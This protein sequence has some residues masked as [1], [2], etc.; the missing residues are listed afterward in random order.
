MK[1]ENQSVYYGI[2]FMFLYLKTYSILSNVFTCLILVLKCN[3]LAIPFVLGVI[4]TG[5]LVLFWKLQSFPTIK[6]WMILTIIV[7]LIISNTFLVPSTFYEGTNS[8]YSL[9]Q[10]SLIGSFITYS[11][12]FNVIGLIVISYIKYSLFKT[13]NRI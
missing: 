9:E 4:I 5:L 8:I 13:K 1:K 11:N 6:L 10:R 2:I 7:L 3:I 12:A